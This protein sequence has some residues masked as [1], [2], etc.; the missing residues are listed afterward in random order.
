V[1]ATSDVDIVATLRFRGF[2]APACDVE[3]IAAVLVGV[4]ELATKDSM[5]G[6]MASRAIQCY[7]WWVICG[8]VLYDL[9]RDCIPA[10]ARFHWCRMLKCMSQE[11]HHTRRLAHYLFPV[12]QLN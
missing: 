1:L 2:P 5:H 4:V 12:F 11:W 9:P 8:T 6:C 3:V 7:L 10:F